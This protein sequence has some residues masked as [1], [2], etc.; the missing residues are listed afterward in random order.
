MADVRR[1]PV[2]VTQIW[3]W[4]MRASCRGMDGEMFF[5]PERER[6]R[7]RADREARAKAVCRGCPVVQQCRDHALAVREPYGVWGGLSV[8]ER[9]EHIRTHTAPSSAIDMDFTG[10]RHH[11][12]GGPTPEPP[13]PA[14]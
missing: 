5:H 7:A 3:D 9:N 2:P 12:S 6:G 13:E 14:A 8:D 10:G 1:L 4:Q 11:H